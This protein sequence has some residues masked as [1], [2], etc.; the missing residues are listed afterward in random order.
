VN[1][2][3]LM[4]A[5]ATRD[6]CI[7]F[8]RWGDVV[9]S[10]SFFVIVTSLF[11]LA[12][13]PK[14]EVLQGIGPG[15]LW[16]AALLST[17]LSLNAMFRADM[18]DG[19]MEELVIGP[20]SLPAAM[21]GKTIAHWLVSGVP[22]IL[23][24]PMLAVTYHLPESQVVALTVTLLLGT[25]TLSLLGSIGAALTAGIRQ[26]GGLLAL[27]VMPLM[28]PVLMFGSRATDLAGS[29]ESIAGPLYLL[30]AFLLLA[31]SLVPLASAAAIRISID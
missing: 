3:S 26:T 21:L 9:S 11:P 5:V 6:L 18:E 31:V 14:R 10:L 1:P 16:I 12:L 22:L 2:F 19:S 24:A 30:A 20:H 4:L 15:V 8:R 23:L 17:L 7:A 13:S 27:L 28:L 25:P 29:G